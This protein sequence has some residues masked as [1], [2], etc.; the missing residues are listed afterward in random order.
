MHVKAIYPGTFDPL[1]QGHYDVAK[2]ARLMFD[3]LVVGVA[4]SPNKQPYFS[5]EERVALATEVLA[6]IGNVTVIP[7]SGLLVDFAHDNDAHVVVRGLRA[8]S[9]FEYEVQIAGVNR[10]LSP[11]IETVFIAASQDYTFLSSSIVREIA[12]LDGDVSSFVHPV[13]LKA[14]ADKKSESA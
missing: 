13:V 5:L 14:L 3:E 2:R 8:I 7:F 1:T 4:A 6:D 10:H 9:D 12:K 11:G